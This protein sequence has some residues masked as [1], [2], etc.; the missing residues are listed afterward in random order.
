MSESCRCQERGFSKNKLDAAVRE[1]GIEYVHIKALGDPKPGR[2]AA[3]AGDHD[4][5]VEI[6]TRHIEG[7]TAQTA[8]RKLAEDVRGKRVCLT[9]FER[10]HEG[11]HRKIVA[12]RLSA[13]IGATIEH[14]VV[15]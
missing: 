14:I 4:L 11:C 12:E 10:H 6:F 2:D 8:L 15:N 13:L 7:D 3:R 9:C 5:F 1:A